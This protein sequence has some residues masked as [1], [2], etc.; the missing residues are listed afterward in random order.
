MLAQEDM[1]PIFSD[2]IWLDNLYLRS[3]FRGVPPGSL[4]LE[5]FITLA[6]MPPLNGTRAGT[7]ARYLTRMTLQGDNQGP[8]VG[9]FADEKVYIEG[10]LPSTT[11]QPAAALTSTAS[12]RGTDA[13]VLILQSLCLTLCRYILIPL[14]LCL[15]DLELPLPGALLSVQHRCTCMDRTNQPKINDHQAICLQASSRISPEPLEECSCH[16]GTTFTQ[17]AG[18]GCCFI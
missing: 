6:A 9:V 2:R 1:V 15:D 4:R 12:C 14:Y 5:K 16:P 7:G 3:H 13:G 10:L 18:L 8:T 17:S 11:L